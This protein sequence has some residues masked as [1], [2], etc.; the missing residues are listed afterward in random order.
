M[1]HT[2][3][4]TPVAGELQNPCTFTP[5]QP[6][7]PALPLAS[8]G[9]NCHLCLWKSEA[10][11]NWKASSKDC[12]LIAAN[13]KQR[14]PAFISN[15]PQKPESD[16]TCCSVCHNGGCHPGQ[17][18]TQDWWLMRT[19]LAGSLSQ[20]CHRT[21]TFITTRHSRRSER[22]KARHR[23]LYLRTSEHAH[24]H[25]HVRRRKSSLRL[26]RSKV[27]IRATD[28]LRVLR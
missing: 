3:C 27:K 24:V 25:V 2:Q 4:Y 10:E 22:Q 11:T 7:I 19:T 5:Q 28:P 8:P 17:R 14:R 20:P 12:G 9:R 21:D 18:A 23:L 1:K 15:P 13:S 26:Q 6:D 16:I